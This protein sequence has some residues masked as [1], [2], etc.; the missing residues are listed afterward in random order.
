MHLLEL[1]EQA[2]AK[3]KSKQNYHMQHHI[4]FLVTIFIHNKSG[5]E[6]RKLK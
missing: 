2:N 1:I 5:K 4:P 3:V 6:K